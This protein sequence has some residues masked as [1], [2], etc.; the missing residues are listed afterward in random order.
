MVFSWI[1]SNNDHKPVDGF[2]EIEELLEQNPEE[3]R[4]TISSFIQ[5]NRTQK[6]EQQDFFRLDR[7]ESPIEEDSTEEYLE[8]GLIWKESVG[9][10]YEIYT[11]TE[12][13]RFVLQNA[14][15]LKKELERLDSL[16][17]ITRREAEH[18]KQANGK[19]EQEYQGS[20]KPIETGERVVWKI[21]NTDK[22]K[23][24]PKLTDKGK[25][26]KQTIRKNREELLRVRELNSKK[27]DY[28]MDFQEKLEILETFA[29]D[30]RL[31][32]RGINE[33]LKE[34]VREE[35][36]KLEEENNRAAVQNLYR[37]A[38]CYAEKK[39]RDS[40]GE[41]YNNFLRG[42]ETIYSGLTDQE[43]ISEEDVDN[44]SQM[45]K[46]FYSEEFS[47]DQ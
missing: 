2:E 40:E 37:T 16:E 44:F 6:T 12:R 23:R 47:P 28:K 29:S 25:K 5:D 15:Q 35:I 45:F 9:E 8:E 26:N 34:D 24:Q 3:R 21:E 42:L 33:Y 36:R 22:G 4:E 7:R 32:V 17:D 1:F 11:F 43:Q 18:M 13:G 30:P 38:K 39:S 19:L 20:T 41:F 46:R 14:E 10:D 27:T 31:P